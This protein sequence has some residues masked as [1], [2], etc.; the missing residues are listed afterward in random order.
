MSA[1]ASANRKALPDE[2][3]SSSFSDRSHPCGHCFISSPD[4]EQNT[5]RSW[6]HRQHVD[7]GCAANA[8]SVHA[9]PA[10]TIGSNLRRAGVQNKAAGWRREPYG[11]IVYEFVQRFAL[12]HDA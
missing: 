2:I 5:A 7:T 11:A 10:A 8:K 3:H 12:P 4:E 1:T 9:Q 6:R